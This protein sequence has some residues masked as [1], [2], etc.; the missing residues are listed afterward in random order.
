MLYRRAEQFRRL[1]L[2]RPSKGDGAA[3]EQTP[4]VAVALA[5]ALALMVVVL[6]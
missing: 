2:A 3:I 4:V 1:P 6:T 5:L